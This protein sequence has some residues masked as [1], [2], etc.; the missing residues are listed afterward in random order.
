MCFCFNISTICASR[1][2]DNNPDEFESRY[3]SSSKG[4]VASA[5]TTNLI[6]LASLALASA[7]VLLLSMWLTVKVTTWFEIV[8]GF[9]EHVNAAG[10]VCATAACFAAVRAIE[11]SNSLPDQVTTAPFL[12]LG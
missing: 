4:E 11:Y 10:L 12:L 2:H 7:L 9:V 1:L 6:T 5:A 8:Q 3:G